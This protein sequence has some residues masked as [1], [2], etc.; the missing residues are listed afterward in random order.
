[1]T[2]KEKF[3]IAAVRLNKGRKTLACARAFRLV[4]ENHIS[5]KVIGAI[6]NK[7]GIKIVSCQLGCFK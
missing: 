7:N 2:Q 1:M 5:L 6:C 4:K 3:V